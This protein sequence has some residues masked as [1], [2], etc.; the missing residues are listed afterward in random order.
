MTIR[1]AAEFEATRAADEAAVQTL[2]QDELDWMTPF[3]D[4]RTLPAGAVLYGAGEPSSDFFVVLE[5]EVEM[6]RSEG[7]GDAEVVVVVHGPGR[8]LGE[9]NLLTGQRPYLTARMRRPGRILVIPPSEFHRLMGSKA[10]LAD[11]IFNA[12]TARRAYLSTGEAARALRIVGSRYSPDAMALRGFA[13]HSQ[14]AHTWIDVEDARD[15]DALLAE[16]GLD[17]A[18]LPAVIMAS[19]VLRRTT[20]GEFSEQLGLTFRPTPGY[21]FDLVVVGTGPSGLASAVY[22]AS[23]GLD[24][25]S[26]DSV[27]IGGQAGASSRIE[28]YVG[29]PN[30]ISGEDLASRA[31]IQAQ[32]LGAK[33][34]APCRAAKLR[35]DHGFHV[36]LLADGSEIATRA[37]II[38]SGAR[39]RRLDVD[40]LARFEGAGVYYAATD[41]EVKVCDGRDAV[42]VG[43]GNSAG[44]ASIYLAQQGSPV[45]LVIRGEDLAKDMSRYLIDRIESDPRIEVLRTTQIRALAGESHLSTIVL[46]HTP[47][48]TRRTIACAGLFCFIGAEPATSWLEGRVALDPDGFVLTDRQLPESV[49]RSTYA[50]R[51]PFQFETSVMGVFAVGDV[52]HGSMKRVAA[53]VGEGSSAVRS[54]YDHLATSSGRAATALRPMR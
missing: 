7:E 20:P 27:A 33:L 4:V 11:V 17:A 34:N 45:K 51:D 25:L 40:G 6:L 47:T 18:D 43:G 5:G 52:R 50:A 3:G 41:L 53:A 30:G 15:V 10:D 23:E 16:M 42:V 37:V 35:P 1:T 46:E 2:S 32:R 54:V 26:V 12:L 13:T 38:A 22:G 31:A 21:L 8:F 44:Q 28:N 24:T 9:L 29:F 19:G 36:V 14:V 48:A 49:L 39:Y